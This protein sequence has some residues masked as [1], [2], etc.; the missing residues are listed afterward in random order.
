MLQLP[1]SWA[2]ARFGDITRSRDGERV[3]VSKE[4]RNGRAKNFDYYGA[5]GVIDKIDGYIF[6]KPL[7]LI[8]EDGANLINRSSPIAFIARGRYWVNNHAHVIDGSSEVFL[9]YLEVFINAT[10]LTPYVTGTAQ[11]K[12]NQAKMNSIPVPVPP[13]SE[14]RRIVAKVDE[15][16]VLCDRL[17]AAQ[18][19]REAARLR[20]GLAALASIDSPPGSPAIA[21]D[22]FANLTGDVHL[23][24]GLRSAV[25]RLAVRGKLLPQDPRD[26][27]A[28]NL[29]A[30]PSASR[31][32]RT[33][34]APDGNSGANDATVTP[35]GWSRVPLAAVLRDLQTGPFGSSLHQSDYRSGGTPVV[36]P[37]SLRQGRIVPVPKMAVDDATLNRLQTF[38]LQ[39]GDIVMARRGEMGRCAV[40]TQNENGWLCGTGSLVLRLIP[41]VAPRYMALAIG[42]PSSREYLAKSAVGITMQ[43]LNQGVLKRMP[44]LLPP[45]AEQNR[46]VAKV[47]ELLALCD[48]L[49]AHLKAGDIARSRLLDALIA[50][51]L[52]EP[53]AQSA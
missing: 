24:D 12:M 53:P 7:L 36:N 3:P 23:V 49:E 14:Q 5:S 45:T 20:F 51:T 1:R 17:E 37:A 11:P 13:E 43:N 18:K 9:R 39:T 15:L 42:A 2:W 34:S 29:L 33:Q 27:P 32:R 28:S 40:V 8:G 21:V 22:T 26:E 31:G 41:G 30:P 6:D 25:Q 16:M 19:E 50:E 47:D 35:R 4:E 10:D 48:Q 46:I 52:A 38:R 44:L